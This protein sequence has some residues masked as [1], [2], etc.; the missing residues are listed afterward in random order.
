MT[1]NGSKDLPVDAGTYEVRA[2]IDDLVFAGFG[3]AVLEIGPATATVS[4]DLDSLSQPI[5]ALT[6]ATATTDP[7]GLNVEIFYGDVTSLP[8]KIGSVLARAVVNEPN[9]VGSVTSTFKVTEATQEVTP[10]ALPAFTMAGAPLNV[11]LAAT[12]SS[13]LPVTFAVSSG[14][15]TVSGNL[16][17]VT[18]PGDIVVVASQAGDDFYAPAEATFTVTVGGQGVPQAAPVLTVVGVS[19][20]NIELS[21]SGS[22]G[23]TVSVMS[24]DTLAGGGSFSDA[25]T[26]TLDDSGN[27]SISLP[28]GGGAGYFKAANQ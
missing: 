12:A 9:W 22:A 3:V 23:A 13:G 5:N 20:G 17:T 1:Y 6:G 11:G 2:I 7:A 24:S 26:V 4:F 25:G 15:A 28:A 16:L 21:I 27:G 19:G 14:D 8:S 10:F 18:Q